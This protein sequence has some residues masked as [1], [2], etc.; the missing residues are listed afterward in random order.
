[1]WN[2]KTIEWI[3]VELTSFCNIACPGCLRQEKKEQVEPILNK[4]II[5]F[6]NLKRW[7][8]FKEFPNLKLLNF[9]GSVD[10]PT[11]H[12][13]ILD[14]VK[15]FKSFTDI[16]IATNGST[17]T[18]E[19]WKE[20]GKSKI[21]VFFGI[22]GTDQKSL[23]KY[24]VGSNFKKVQ[25]NWRA[26]IKAGGKATWQFI[27]FEYNQHLLEQAEQMSKDEGFKNFRTI[28]SHR[29]GSGEVKKEVEEEKE[30]QCKYGTLKRLGEDV[31]KSLNCLYVKF[32]NVYGIEKE[33]EKSHVITDFVLMALNRSKKRSR[34]RK[35]KS[36]QIWQSKKIIHKSYWCAFTLLLFKFRS[37]RNGCH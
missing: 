21:S 22:D 7:I 13:D 30:I 1:M 29:E 35:R 5:D 36:M 17:K 8:T 16:N 33:I 34:R 37:F 32:W 12:P 15:H 20:L 6:D 26:F 19:F 27:V 24:R 23:E 25:E 14:I 28:W 11:L 18:K 3:D 10:E 31:S 2:N 4:D 9:C